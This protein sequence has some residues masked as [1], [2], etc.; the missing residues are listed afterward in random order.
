MAMN[1]LASKI[2]GAIQKTKNPSMWRTKS[3]VISSRVYGAL[4]HKFECL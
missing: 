4:Q 1:G 2:K 3:R